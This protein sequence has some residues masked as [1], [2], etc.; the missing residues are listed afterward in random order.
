MKY[1]FLLPLLTALCLGLN[2]TSSYALTLKIATIVPDGTNWMKT[3]RAAAKDIKKSTEGR[4]KIR[5]FPG[6]VM[7]NDS[8]VLRKMRIGQLHGGAVTAGALSSFTKKVQI[9]GLPF[10]FQNIDEVNHVRPKFDKTIIQALKEKKLIVL[11]ISNG[12]FAYLMSGQSIRTSDDVAKQKVWVPEGD[13]IAKTTFNNGNITPVPLPV[14]DVYTSLQTGLINTVATNATGA[15]A[16]QWHT[17]LKYA[18][19]FPLVFLTGMMVVDERAF[20][21]ISSSDQAVVKEIM[22]NA[23]KRMDKQNMLDD[24]SAK[25]ALVNNGMTYITLSEQDKQAWRE[26]AQKAV[27]ELKDKNVYPAALYEQL[28]SELKAFRAR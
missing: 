27:D 3:M 1:R 28:K 12:G 23:F 5:F 17:K 26:L 25:Q 4:V 6:G 20:K 24:V 14:S 10:A 22:G 13:I 16:L 2:A 18:I 11:G 15:I 19:D 8:S 9:Y 21:K 7:G